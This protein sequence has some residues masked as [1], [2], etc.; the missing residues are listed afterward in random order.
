[1]LQNSRKLYTVKTTHMLNVRVKLFF[2]DFSDIIAQRGVVADTNS[3]SRAIDHEGEKL[4][5]IADLTQ[6]QP[7]RLTAQG[8]Y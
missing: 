7:S 8:V 2:L 4:E 5:R 3:V 6:L 1:M